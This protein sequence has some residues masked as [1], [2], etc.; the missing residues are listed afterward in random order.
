MLLGFFV[1]LAIVAVKLIPALLNNRKETR[2]T[3]LANVKEVQL[4]EIGVR[5]KEAAARLAQANAT[6]GLTE[7]LQ[8]SSEVTEELSIFL[9]RSNELAKQANGRMD[10][11]EAE[12]ADIRNVVTS[13]IEN[14]KKGEAA[15]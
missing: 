13:I 8:K 3:E 4:A 6:N 10:A 15:T 7:Q 1:I 11:I 14:L 5:D 2:L 9:K 12:T